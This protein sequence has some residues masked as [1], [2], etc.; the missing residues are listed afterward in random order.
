MILL[1]PPWKRTVKESEG[2][3]QRVKPRRAE[4]HRNQNGGHLRSSVEVVVTKL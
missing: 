2:K 1:F 4:C 3:P